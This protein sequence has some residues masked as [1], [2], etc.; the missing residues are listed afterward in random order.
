MQPLK[1]GTYAISHYYDVQNLRRYLVSH[2][3]IS[4]LIGPNSFSFLL[5]LEEKWFK[6]ISKSKLRTYVHLSNFKSDVTSSLC[7]SSLVAQLR[8]AVLLRRKTDVVKK[9][10]I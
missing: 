3:D 2:H 8:A 5:K 4:I 7:S 6:N 10:K 1:Q 9:K